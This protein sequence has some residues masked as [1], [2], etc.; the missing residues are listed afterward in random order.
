MFFFLA[1]RLYGDVVVTQL[2]EQGM[3]QETV[4]TCDEVSLRL[5]LL[6]DF[7]CLLDLHSL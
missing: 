7:H 1:I 2:L 5:L 6:G 3:A 4:S